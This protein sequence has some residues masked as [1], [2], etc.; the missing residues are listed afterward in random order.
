MA[1][2]ALIFGGGGHAK[3]IIE[4]LRAVEPAIELAV[5]DDDCAKVLTAMLGVPVV[6]GREWMDENW[7]DAEVALAIGN[8]G[9]RAA[10]ASWL[11]K[12]DRSV[13]TVVHPSAIVSPSASVGEGTFLA[14]GCVIN[15]EAVIGA[16]AIVN[17][18]ASI[19]HDC[20][21]GAGAHIAPGAHL[22]GDVVIGE[23]ALIGAGAVVT[24]GVRVGM[25]AVIGAGATVVDHVEAGA[26]VVGTPARSR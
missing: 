25:D 17:T 12:R 20:R 11:F 7:P 2:R 8:N 5:I 21:I 3:V 24:P 15:A 23:R 4:T 9:A 10:A 22:C 16:H 19:D 13:V 26:C 1:N 14:P 18:A 6:G